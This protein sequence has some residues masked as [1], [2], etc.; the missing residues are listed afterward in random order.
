MAQSVVNGEFAAVAVAFD[1]LNA[2]LD[3]CTGFLDQGLELVGAPV[4][5]VALIE[6]AV[7]SEM[8]DAAH[9]CCSGLRG[10]LMMM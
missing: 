5:R 1:A 6:T 8:A 3:V 7:E 9:D 4:M 2:G 10:I